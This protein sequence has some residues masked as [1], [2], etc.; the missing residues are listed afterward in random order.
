[1]AR[2]GGNVMPISPWAGRGTSDCRMTM[3]AGSRWRNLAVQLGQHSKGPYSIEQSS[4]RRGRALRRPLLGGNGDAVNSPGNPPGAQG[5]GGGCRRRDCGGRLRR[6][7]RAKL[8]GHA[9]G[10]NGWGA[11][12]SPRARSASCSRERVD[13]RRGGRLPGRGRLGLLDGRGWADRG[14]R[15]DARPGLRTPSRLPWSTTSA[16]PRSRERWL[17]R[18][19]RSIPR[20]APQ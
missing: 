5:L 3:S 12:C 4:P 1:M 18:S 13:L 7:C 20:T 2:A 14:A 6:C 11:S 16:G 15:R 10:A 17:S 9:S 19:N 8:G